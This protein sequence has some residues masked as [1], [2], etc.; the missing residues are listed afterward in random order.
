MVQSG[1]EA[2]ARLTQ[3][4]TDAQARAREL[5]A[6]IADPAKINAAVPEWRAAQQRIERERLAQQKAEQEKRLAAMRDAEER[7][8]AAQTKKRAAEEAEADAQ[9]RA[10]AQREVE[11]E[12]ARAIRRDLGAILDRI[13]ATGR[14]IIDARET[15][16]AE[17][18]E[19]E[20][21]VEIVQ[22]RH[23]W[24]LRA[25]EYRE[26]IAAIVEGILALRAAGAALESEAQTAASSSKIA[27]RLQA[28]KK[29]MAS[30]RPTLLDRGDLETL[31]REA[32]GARAEHERAVRTLAERRGSLV[33]TVERTMQLSA[34]LQ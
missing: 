32:E 34:S 31:E 14:A 20:K 9:R 12:R 22:R 15:A 28:M 16:R 11:Q 27:E 8:R 6:A 13:A 10:E 33:R 25:P 18:A 7:E 23:G 2:H 21:D 30:D 26:P 4:V 3:C 17:L 29:R 19:V 24:A 1:Q 5:R